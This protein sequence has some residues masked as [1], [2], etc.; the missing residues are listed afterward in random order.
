MKGVGIHH[1]GMLRA[2]RTLTE[3]LFQ[4]GLIKILCCTSTLSWGVNLP[5]HTVI[6]KG[7]EMYDPSRGGFI[8]VLVFWMSCT[9]LAGRPQYDNSGHAIL[10]TSHASLNKWDCSYRKCPLKVVSLK[11]SRII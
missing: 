3:Q 6:I 7:K 9:S 11:P 1:A 8:E 4:Q 2:D 10:L 5:A